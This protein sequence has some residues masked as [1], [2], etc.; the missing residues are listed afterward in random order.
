MNKFTLSLAGA[1]L[2]FSFPAQ[3]EIFSL[4]Q[5]TPAQTQPVF[6]TLGS[7]LFFKPIEPASGYGKLWGLGIGV[8]ANA[9]STSAISTVVSGLS[10]SVLP[11]A[12][13][14]AGITLPGGITLEAGYLPT[15]T[16]QNTTFGKTAFG[17]KWN[18]N[19]ALFTSLPFDIAV[20]AGITSGTLAYLQTSGGANINVNYS[21][22]IFTANL[23]VS[24]NFVLVEPFA[25]IG[26][27][28]HSSTLSG[29]GTGTIF[30]AGYPAA[31]TSITG[32]SA[33]LW[34]HA[35][36][37][38]NLQFLRISASVDYAFGLVSGNGKVAFSI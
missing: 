26:L 20:R 28:N 10:T 34:M 21:T 29:T 23:I 16:Y 7:M 2:L 31:T 38:L 11:M 9:T 24:K 19:R 15:F 36:V 12:D 4:P 32:T 30:G 25:G 3:A 37:L 1:L 18:I 8:S 13:I 33:T 5:L 27:A 22:S 35:G 14:N 17:A 6:N